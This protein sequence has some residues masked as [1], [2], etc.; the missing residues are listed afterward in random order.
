MPRLPVRI[1]VEETATSQLVFG[2]WFLLAGLA[3]G[4]LIVSLLMRWVGWI[5]RSI[6][7][8]VERS[9]LFAEPGFKVFFS[10]V[11]GLIALRG[12]VLLLVYALAKAG[13]I[14]SPWQ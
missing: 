6:G 13:L 5:N 1:F 3:V 10:I 11:L 2:L 9:Y 12:M 7:G 14:Q 4:P 8:F